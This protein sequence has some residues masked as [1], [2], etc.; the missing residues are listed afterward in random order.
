MLPDSPEHRYTYITQRQAELRAEAATNRAARAPA[1]RP[2]AYRVRG[3]HFHLGALL[4]VIG[5]GLC[6]E[7]GRNLDPAH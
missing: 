7:D 2:Q 4:I 5:R 3:V 6:E 1:R